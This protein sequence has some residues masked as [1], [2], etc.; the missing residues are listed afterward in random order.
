MLWIGL[1]V[2]GCGRIEYELLRRS[3]GGPDAADQGAD[4]VD[5]EAYRQ[6]FSAPEVIAALSTSDA[7]D[8]PCVSA[9]L[10]ELY[11]SSNRAGLGNNDIWRT[12]RTLPTDPWGTPLLV[13]EVSS[14]SED[15][16]PAIADN[17]RAM[18]FSS[19]RSGGW[20]IWFSTRT[21]TRGPWSVPVEIP[22]LSPMGFENGSPAPFAGDLGMV[23]RSDSG[24]AGDM[25]LLLSRRVSDTSRW[26]PLEPLLELNTMFDDQNADVVGSGER[27]YFDSN[28]DGSYTIY[29][30]VYDLAGSRFGPPA[31][32]VE[33][34]GPGGDGDPSL[35]PDERYIVFERGDDIWEAHR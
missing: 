28:R 23:I 17:G 2:P 35:S 13:A 24:S 22:E 21:D 20:A 25:E 7:D 4:A 32:V 3:D 9:D 14:A 16:A 26:G 33:L 30:A 5:G 31:R 12:V 19:R 6:P 27:I 11:F 1:F 15:E 10:R 18:W 29:M 8:D 34:D